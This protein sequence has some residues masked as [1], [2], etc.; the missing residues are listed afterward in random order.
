MQIIKYL[1]VETQVQLFKHLLEKFNIH[2]LSSCFISLKP[3]EV[4][5]KEL[6]SSLL[7]QCLQ[8]V[9]QHE[10]TLD[11]STLRSIRKIYKRC[12]KYATHKDILSHVVPLAPSCI[13]LLV[14]CVTDSDD[15]Q[16]EK[17]CKWFA[18]C[19]LQ[20]GSYHVVH[21]HIILNMMDTLVTYKLYTENNY[22]ESSSFEELLLN[23]I[24]FDKNLLSKYSNEIIVSLL[25]DRSNSLLFSF[26]RQ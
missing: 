26:P 14:K 5:E 3:N 18:V 10:N 13:N 21:E 8:I 20:A 6:S 11:T 19:S 7:K 23:S 2:S 17:I 15:E 12:M 9:S 4:L 1:P 24:S 22:F 16:V 25:K